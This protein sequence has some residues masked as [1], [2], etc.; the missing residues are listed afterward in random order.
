MW[1]KYDS[2]GRQITSAQS[3]LEVQYNVASVTLTNFVGT[4]N[5]IGNFTTMD[6]VPNI[7]TESAT[8]AAHYV[9]CNFTGVPQYNILIVRTRYQC[10]G[11]GHTI[12]VLLRD[13]SGAGYTASKAALADVSY[14]GDWTYLAYKLT[15]TEQTNCLSGGAAIVRFEHASNGTAGHILQVDA[16]YLVYCP[17]QDYQTVAPIMGRVL[18][19][20]VF[21]SGT[22]YTPTSGTGRIRVELFGAGGGGGGVASA[23]AAQIT[24]GSGGASGGY[25]RV[26]ANICTGQTCAYTIGGAGAAGASG[27]GNGGA[28]S[29]STF[30]LPSA[31]VATA[32]GGLGGKFA[33]TGVTDIIVEGG[34][35]GA[36]STCT[37]T[38]AVLGQ[39]AHGQEGH[40]TSGTVGY[41]GAGA[42]I[43][44]A[45]AGGASRTTQG[46]G[47]NGSNSGGGGGAF[48]VNAG[49][50]QA[51]G[52]GGAGL[53]IVTEYS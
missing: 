29:N 35:P 49:A 43:G 32:I 41:A 15:P 25:L 8:A 21:T 48:S 23:S 3:G 45:G 19:Q 37:E 26:Y 18:A 13:Y 53:L 38:G 40:R 7:Y 47:N 39:G 24:I 17:D 9:D 30:T 31:V 36:I 27:G 6:N 16:C 5:S 11:G 2:S 50:A 52:A 33:A 4:V 1:T 28:G 22:T 44:I 51:G 10:W 12:N 42:S 20:R 14:I 46:A 34:N